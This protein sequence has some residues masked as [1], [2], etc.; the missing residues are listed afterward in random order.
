[1]VYE[2]EKGSA[3]GGRLATRPRLERYEPAFRENEID[4]DAL[5]ELTEAD[6]ATLGLPL[7]SR[8]KLL[9]AS[10][11]LRQG[12]LPSPAVAP[13]SEVPLPVSVTASEAE[14]RQLTVMFCDLVGS[15]ALSTRLDPEDLRAVIGACHRC[16]AAVIERAGGFVAKY[17]GDGV[18]VRAAND[19][20]DAALLPRGIVVAA[21]RRAL[22]AARPPPQRQKER[23]L[24]AL[25]AQV[26]GLSTRQPVL[27]RFEDAQWSDPTSL[28]LVDLIID[29][30]PRCRYCRSSPAGAEWR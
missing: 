26:A 22:S 10:A 14:R 21:H 17:M 7:G 12:A 28:E 11:A 6:L 19:L 1:M 9:K 30:G 13:H 5:P 18:L 25:V 4:A 29:R 15:T 8:R 24:A 16:V 2:R 3:T 23:T 20:G 27:M